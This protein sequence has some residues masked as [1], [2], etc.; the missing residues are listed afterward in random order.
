MKNEQKSSEKTPYIPFLIIAICHY[1]TAIIWAFSKNAGMSGM[2]ICL[3][4]AFLCI[5]ISY[6]N[7]NKEKDETEDDDDK[8][9]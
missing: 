1:I 9:E 5:A 6:R 2:Y 4:S 8:K 3:G 7:K